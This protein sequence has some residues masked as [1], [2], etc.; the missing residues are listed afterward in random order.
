MAASQDVLK[1]P[2]KQP[3]SKFPATRRDDIALWA[4]ILCSTLLAYLPALHGSPVWDDNNHLTRPDLQTFHGL[5]RIWFEVGASQQYYPLLHSAFWLE[6]RIWGD[7]VLGYHL[8]NV[9]LHALSACLVVLIARQLSLKGAWLAGFVFALHPVQVESVAWISEQKSTLSGVF[10]LAAL[11]VYL[12]FNRSRLKQKY[13]LATGLFVLALMSKTVTAV[14]PAVILVILWWRRGKLDWKRDVRPLVPWF[15]IGMCAGLFTSWVERKFIGASGADFVLTPL[16]RVLIAG[17]V[18]LFYAGKLL[19]PAKLA[20]FYPHWNVDAAVWWQWLFPVGVLALAAGLWW[21][22]RRNRGPLASLLIFTGA[23]FPVL[24]FLN[25]FPFR[26]SYV[27]NHFQYLACLGILVPGVVLLAKASERLRLGNAGAAAGS[28]LLILVLGGLTWQES[29]MYRDIETLYR[30]SIELNPASY[31]AHYNLGTVLTEK[32]GRFP[33]AIG[34]FEAALEIH[35]DLAEAHNGLG[36]AFSRTPGRLDDAFAEFQLALEIQP[37]YAE[38]YNNLGN[39]LSKAPGREQD[40]IADYRAAIEIR[41]DYSEAHFNLGSV[42]SRIPGRTPDAI[43]EYQAAIKANPDYAEAHNNL[44][45]L[46]AAT[47][48]RTQDAIAEYQAAIKAKPDYAE[49]HSNLGVL[50]AAAPGRTQDAIGEFE[51]AI[52]ANPDYAEAHNNLGILLAVTPGRMRDAIAEYQA[53][54]NIRPDYAEAHVNLGNALSHTPG[55][56]RDAIAEYRA[57]LQARPDFVEAHNYLGSALSQMPGQMAEAIAEYRAALKIRPNYAE[58][59]F[60]LG[61]LLSQIP[62]HA[63]EAAAEYQAVLRSRPDLASVVNERL[64]ALHSAQAH[65]GK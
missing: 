29:R 43:A 10:C 41:P 37:S 2:T 7:A 61:N 8:V 11:L 23:L 24:G 28:A 3:E 53:A 58:A 31:I 50:L 20:F 62:G 59:H 27:A 57:A 64:K 32:P 25:V 9:V 55:R 12:H 26:Y 63:Q 13:W 4:A 40:A 54:L 1:G 17:R 35:P 42:L 47:P 15:A 56:M 49:A 19:W 14:L 44:G 65:A 34:E 33:E 48:G 52:K 22:A 21:V 38:A 45:I 5:W 60:N 6:H 51:A 46:L 39:L 36:F 18:I 30:T 16:Q